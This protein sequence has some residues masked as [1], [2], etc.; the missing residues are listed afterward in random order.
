MSARV[1]SWPGD[2]IFV[3][4]F[5]RVR[6]R[7]VFFALRPLSFGEGLTLHLALTMIYVLMCVPVVHSRLSYGL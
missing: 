7:P 1:R 6:S 3:P 5:V 2:H 4:N